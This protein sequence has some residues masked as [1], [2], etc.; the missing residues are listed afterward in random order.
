MTEAKT[1]RQA[2]TKMVEKTSQT[3]PQ[4]DKHDPESKNATC[5]NHI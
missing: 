4:K 3:I 2:K 1:E 5:I